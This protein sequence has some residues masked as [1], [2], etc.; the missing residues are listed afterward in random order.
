MSESG[1]AAD[2]RP[3]PLSGVRVVEVGVWHA[4][5]GASAILGDL[6]AEVIKVESLRGDPERT[7]GTFGRMAVKSPTVKPG[8]NMLF[9]MSN[10]N[11]R[12]V[13]LDLASA[14][15]RQVLHRLIESCDV[16]LCNLRQSS[17]QALGIAA[18]DV[19]EVNPMTIYVDVNAF[20]HHGPYASTGGFDPLGQA[21]SGMMYTT[22]SEEPMTLSWIVLDQLT[23]ITASHAAIT[24]LYAREREGRGQEVSTSLYGAG[25]W[26]EHANL[27]FE[28]LAPEPMEFDWDRR[29]VSPLRSTFPCKD[30]NWIVST[31]HPPHRGWPEFCA[32]IERPDLVADP[33]F[34]TDEK[35]SG[36]LELYAVLDEV[37]LSRTRDEWLEIFA[38]ADLFF[39][40]A[41]RVADVLD[42]EQAEA[43]GYIVPFEHP[44]LGRIKI[45]G[46]PV[47]FGHHRAGTRTAAPA[48]GEHSVA[49][50]TELGYSTDEIDA[51]VD[52]GIVAAGGAS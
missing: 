46:Y 32:A 25:V 43:N 18:E 41:N 45:P 51:L 28:S 52:R 22:G 38:A 26:F 2:D 13:S 1:A 42:D 48:L 44:F 8:W 34:D 14:D 33:R 12:S 7:H 21:M 15:G 9:E 10:R 31:N 5:P 37:F 20:G 50:L 3:G 17:R 30:G 47:R 49:V 40:P 29:A 35:R 4:G 16:F 6:G 39:V 23:S 11:K 19:L 27:L 36:S 24:A